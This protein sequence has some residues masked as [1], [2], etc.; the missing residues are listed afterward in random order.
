MTLISKSLKMFFLHDV[1]EY[2][3]RTR[4]A[5]WSPRNFVI[6]AAR[7]IYTTRLLRPKFTIA[8]FYLGILGL[9]KQ[10]KGLDLLRRKSFTKNNNCIFY[11]T[12]RRPRHDPKA[13]MTKVKLEIVHLKSIHTPPPYSLE[14]LLKTYSRHTCNCIILTTR[15]TPHP[16]P[17]THI[18][19]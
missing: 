7:Y 17:P 19:F 12:I 13:F 16:T 2:S 15:A 3:F 9:W 10:W 6:F 5:R 1:R 18:A 11:F 14:G 8:C 4:H